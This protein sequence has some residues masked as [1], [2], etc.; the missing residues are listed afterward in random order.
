MVFSLTSFMTVGPRVTREGGETDILATFVHEDD[1]I[2]D[3]ERFVGTGFSDTFVYQASESDSNTG[4][5]TITMDGG[6]GNDTFRNGGT[7]DRFIAIGGFGN[8]TFNVNAGLNGSGAR[9]TLIGGGG[10]DTF[11]F[12]NDA[13]PDSVD[14]GDGTDL[15][16]F[17]SFTQSVVDL[18]DFTSIEN[19]TSGKPGV[20]LIGHTRK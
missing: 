1:R 12:G 20:L 18:N 2:L 8:D 5:P 16:S 3:T 6:F 10:D 14:G 13:G 17:A 9:T 15:M 11:R 4:F 19:A 7:F